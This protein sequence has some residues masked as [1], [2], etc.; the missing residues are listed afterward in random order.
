MINLTNYEF[1]GIVIPDVQV[2]LKMSRY[3]LIDRNLILTATYSV[4]DSTT[5][6]QTRNIEKKLT[7]EE[8]AILADLLEGHASGLI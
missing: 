4:P 6:F 7:P 1:N 8:G 2:D 5:P 3:D